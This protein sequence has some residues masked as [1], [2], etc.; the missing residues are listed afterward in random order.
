MPE[1]MAE[2]SGFR[3]LAL[4]TKVVKVWVSAGHLA[5]LPIVSPEHAIGHIPSVE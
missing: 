3:N 1:L 2:A 4:M 5:E